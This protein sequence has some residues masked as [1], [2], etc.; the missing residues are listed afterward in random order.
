MLENTKLTDSI[1]TRDDHM[2]G[3]TLFLHRNPG[4]GVYPCH[5]PAS[6]TEA[7]ITLPDYVLFL[8]C[9]EHESSTRVL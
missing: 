8:Y 9:I 4:N 6:L 7:T 2:F 5:F 1:E 3:M